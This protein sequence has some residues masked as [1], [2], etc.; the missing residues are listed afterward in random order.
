MQKCF[1]LGSRL[2]AA[3][4]C[5][6]QKQST[7]VA[8]AVLL[9]LGQFSYNSE[10]NNAVS[11]RYQSGRD[12]YVW[13]Y[14]IIAVLPIVPVVISVGVRHDS[15]GIRDQDGNLTLYVCNGQGNY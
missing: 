10:S 15:Y 5:S 6:S 4:P 7:L 2:I 12:S 14:L 11:I 3:T 8:I 1:T 13:Q 9:F